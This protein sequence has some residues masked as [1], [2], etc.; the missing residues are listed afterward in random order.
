[1]ELLRGLPGP[2][3]DEEAVLL[4]D[5]VEVLVRLAVAQV[6]DRPGEVNGAHT[7]LRLH[8]LGAILVLW[9]KL[10]TLPTEVG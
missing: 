8:T 6:G 3:G 9:G 4:D 5:A 1:M 7:V 2:E 10:G